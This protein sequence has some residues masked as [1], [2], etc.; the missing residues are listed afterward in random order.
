MNRVKNLSIPLISALVASSVMPVNADLVFG[1]SSLKEY[2]QKKDGINFRG[3]EFDVFIRDGNLIYVG[4]CSRREFWP[5]NIPRDPCPG[6]ST[7]FLTA[8]NIA[9]AQVL[10]QAEIGG[11]GFSPVGPYFWATSVAPAIVIEPRVASEGQLISAPAST[12]ARPSRGFEDRSFAAQ[13]NLLNTA[14]REYV[15]SIYENN[16]AYSKNQNSRFN[17]DIVPG[18]YQYTFPRMGMP[19]VPAPFKA[20]I[21]PMADILRT[22]NK[23][24]RGFEFGTL[25]KNFF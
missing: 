2:R 24:K 23:Q 13:Y 9:D 10:E 4:G 19:E 12:L 22:V 15:F 17:S 18:V 14:V 6:G 7:A 3:G 1:L 21:F 20:T 11:F 5:P 25:N 8:G 16:K